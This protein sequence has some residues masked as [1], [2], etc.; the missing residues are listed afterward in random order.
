MS[1]SKGRVSTWIMHRSGHRRAKPNILLSCALLNARILKETT[2]NKQGCMLDVES[3]ETSEWKGF[4]PVVCCSRREHRWIGSSRL[5]CETGNET[6]SKAKLLIRRC[7]RC[8]SCSVLE[9][10]RNSVCASGVIESF[11]LDAS[12]LLVE[13]A[14]KL[15][16]GSISW[17]TDAKRTAGPTSSLSPAF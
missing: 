11:S 3:K 2:S 13:S 4:H 12:L 8:V 16:A 1:S 7:C 17:L 5:T 15:N 9:R 10:F 14:C 6:G